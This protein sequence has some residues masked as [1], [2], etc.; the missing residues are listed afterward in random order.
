MA[1]PLR[2]KR[3]PL[4]VGLA[5]LAGAA[6]LLAGCST[7]GGSSEAGPTTAATG[8]TAETT[9]PTPTQPPTTTEPEVPAGPTLRVNLGLEPATL[10]PDRAT[11]PAARNVLEAIL[12]P[13]VRLDPSGALVPE[14]AKRW[15]FTNDGL[16]VT[17]HLRPGGVWTNGDPV[18]AADYEYSWKR[19][20]APER[21]SANASQF[22]GIVGAEAYHD[23]D[24]K[25]EDCR[26]LRENVGVEA[27]DDV[28][29]EV[30]LSRRQ[31]W[32]VYRVADPAFLAV[33]EPTVRQYPKR[34]YQPANIVTNGPYTLAAWDHNTSITLQK[35]DQWR[36][37]GSVSVAVIQ[38]SMIADPTAGL[39]AFEGGD[40]DACIDSQC[41]PD[42]EIARLVSSTEYQS[43]PALEG[44]Y[45]GVR[46]D[47]VTDLDQRKAIAL[48]LDRKSIVADVLPRER[49]AT[50]LTPAGMPGFDEIRTNYVRPKARTGKADR[51]EQA[52]ESP[53]KKLR[54]T[55]PTGEDALAE[56]IQGQL[57][58]QLGLDVKLKE[59]PPTSPGKNADLYLFRIRADI[60]D[61]IAFLGLF[62]C[63]GSLNQ[64]GFCDEAYDA[65]I[66]D[67]RKAVDDD[68]RFG[69][70]GNL[71]AMLTSKNG[72]FPL[73]PLTW[74]TT[75]TLRTTA[76][77]GLEP[78]ALGL[79]DFATV[80]VSGA[81]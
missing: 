6:V 77:D 69:I 56:A 40:L 60:A 8:T 48:A 27:L 5:T 62:T 7:G 18:T 67:A 74:S 49:P 32:F 54:L 15:E 80:S 42:T 45:M 3:L 21:A 51:L 50:S 4:F 61:A 75:G 53:V 38:G 28:T 41:L 68:A 79:Y 11:D 26:T 76:V 65:Q 31:P 64:S 43:S 22:F 44:A 47:R 13:L 30:R 19:A 73:I 17:F 20:L 16:T 2:W 81:Q 35:W 1:A 23:C 71:E 36:R 57:A 33:H 37:A 24:P 9:T 25:E 70:Y 78:N 63:D 29:L 59:R 14:L 55:Y 39:A 52:A 66:D 46:L 58:V 12:E 34:W 10:E 72:A